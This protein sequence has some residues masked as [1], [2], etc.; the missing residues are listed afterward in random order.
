MIELPQCRWRGL[1]LSP[2]RYD[3][4]SPKLIVSPEGVP[5]E[6]CRQ[7]YC[8]DHEP[9]ANPPALGPAPPR[10]FVCRELGV[11]LRDDELVARGFDLAKCGCRSKVRYCALHELCTT[12]SPREGMACC[13]TCPDYDDGLVARA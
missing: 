6:L 11:P 8:C 3:C 1:E 9:V 10:R 2:G 7:C 13:A 4:R 12:G 5:G